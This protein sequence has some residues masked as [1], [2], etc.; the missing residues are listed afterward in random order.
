M[1]EIYHYG[2]QHVLIITLFV[3]S[4]ALAASLFLGKGKLGGV[5]TDKT[6]SVQ[7]LMVA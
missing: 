2:V 5:Q 6:K 1:R 3:I 7:G 4:V